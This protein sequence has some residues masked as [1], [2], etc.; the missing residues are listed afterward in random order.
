[1]PRNI[2]IICCLCISLLQAQKTSIDS[3][4]QVLN[5]SGN[6][7]HL[8]HAHLE[9]SKNLS[10][11]KK[12]SI[13]YHLREAKHIATNNNLDSLLLASTVEL[14]KRH[15]RFNSDV[16]STS[17]YLEKGYKLNTK[18]KSDAVL[19]HLNLMKSYLLEHEGKSAEAIQLHLE[20]LEVADRLNDLKGK[21]SIY[22]GISGIYRVQ[23]NGQKAVEYME[24]AKA[25]ADQL[26]DSFLRTKLMISLN[27]ALA[28]D[29]NG[30]R[31]KGEELLK[32]ILP[33]SKKESSFGEAIIAH[34]LG[35]FY[36]LDGKYEEA[37]I[38]LTTAIN[39]KEWSDIPQRRIASLKELSTLY[40]ERNRPKEAV[41]LAKEVYSLAKDLDFQYHIEDATRNLSEAY[42]MIGDYKNSVRLKN[43]YIDVIKDMFDED[44]NSLMLELD[45]KYQTGEKEKEIQNLEIQRK[46]D[47]RNVIIGILGALLLFSL[48]CYSR[49]YH[50]KKSKF[51]LKQKELE[52]VAEK[53]KSDLI[54]LRFQNEKIYSLQQEQEKE[55]IALELKL[56]EKELTT[57]AMTLLQ[58]NK[59]YESLIERL[60]IIKSSSGDKEANQ[61]IAAILNETKA[62][63]TSYNWEEFQ[64]IFEKVHLNFYKNLI[65][66][67]P[68]ITP[69]E[70]KISAFL[71]LGLTTKDIS[72]ITNQ[73]AHSILIARSRLRKKLG[74]SKEKSLVEFINTF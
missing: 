29:V 39:S 71:K 32:S 28:Y 48:L 60:K 18:I 67:F 46:I 66:Q 6:S 70:K 22:S 21:A 16:D 42:E 56:K 5:T 73:T 23:G 13:F 53:D 50:R 35:R 65:E 62:S 41:I 33:L 14:T 27:L 2:T 1:M 10:S 47:R 11:L 69:N 15:Y 59:H 7:N 58:Q 64:L 36:I 34:N 3:L 12:D 45:A 31:P 49:I 43:E 63:L 40:M 30:S 20:N 8:G 37:E 61:K 4:Y 44:K 72:A 52:I 55:I 68:N 54:E 51:L 17:Y 74:L 57:N 24:F 26:D 38:L 19:Y 9:I 25:T